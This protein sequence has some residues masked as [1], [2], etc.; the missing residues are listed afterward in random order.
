MISEK[1]LYK[2]LDFV[3]EK[4]EFIYQLWSLD[5]IEKDVFMDYVKRNIFD[6]KYRDFKKIQRKFLN[7]LL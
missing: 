4:N 1:Q 6:K 7:I 5:L 3:K 2:L